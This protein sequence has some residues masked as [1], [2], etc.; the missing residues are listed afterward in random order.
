MIFEGLTESQSNPRSLKV[1]AAAKGSAGAAAIRT[2]AVE[3]MGVLDML[4]SYKWVSYLYQGCQC[5]PAPMDRPSS[6]V[7][8]AWKEAF[9]P[10]LGL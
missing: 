8:E 10:S 2:P 3:G 6:E 5:Q 4:R 1:F 9:S 7:H